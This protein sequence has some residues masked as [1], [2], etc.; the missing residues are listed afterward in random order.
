M[1]ARKFVERLG[2]LPEPGA[3]GPARKVEGV[4][5]KAPRFG[6]ATGEA[7]VTLECHHMYS[8]VVDK[9]VNQFKGAYPC[10]KCR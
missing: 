3:E 9:F 2:T 8:V 7:I 5:Y 10:Q 4:E 6:T 1:S